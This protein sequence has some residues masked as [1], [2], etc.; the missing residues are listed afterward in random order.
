MKFITYSLVALPFVVILDLLWFGGIA[1]SFYKTQ[2]G[3]LMRI[4]DGSLSPRI[5]PTIIT[6]LTMALV[7]GIFAVP[8]ALQVTLLKSFAYGAA[9][10]LLVYG[11]YNFTNLAVLAGWNWK[12]AIVDTLWGGVIFGLVTVVVTK[13]VT[14]FKI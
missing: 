14:H 5:W 3:S 13:I 1:S 7:I 6:Y 4:I 8:P 2:I 11:I 12:I 10:G 9:L